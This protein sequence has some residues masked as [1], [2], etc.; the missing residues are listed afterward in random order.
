MHVVFY[1]GFS[2]LPHFQIF[3]TRRRGRVAASASVSAEPFH[4]E[5]HFVCVISAAHKKKR[6]YCS[7][8]KAALM[9][10]SLVFVL[11]S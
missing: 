6:R 8:M 2:V 11:Y 10:A 5:L 1:G 9:A 4:D 7:N 3:S